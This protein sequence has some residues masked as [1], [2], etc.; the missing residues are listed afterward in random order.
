MMRMRSDNDYYVYV[1]FRPNGIP[2]YVGKGKGRR[3]EHHARFSH[4][5]HLK[6]IYN[7]AGGIL[8]LIKIRQGLTDSQACETERAF[9]AAIGRLD[10]G[11]G[12]L[13]N[14]SDGGEGLSGHIKTAETRAKLSASLKGI[15]RN[16]EWRENQRK[17]QTG[18]PRSAETRIKMSAAHMG[19]PRPDLS[20]L[21]KGRPAPWVAT[22]LLGTKC[23][24][25]SE[26][27]KGN[28]FCLGKNLRNQNATRKLTEAHVIEI[29]QRILAGE[30][31]Q[32]IAESF[33][34]H[35]SRISSIATE[36]SWK[37]IQ[38]ANSITSS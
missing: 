32:S 14:F 9:I 15:P 38:L 20:E 12:P 5:K 37:H 19:K 34:V 18:L 28:K 11:K 26:R 36:R 10:L 13:V 16:L 23:P 2:C 21:F 27:M 3:A 6:R 31:H 4:N 35:K 33:G 7:Q 8:P 29:K 25:H 30:R 24:E 22:R 1:I 17:S